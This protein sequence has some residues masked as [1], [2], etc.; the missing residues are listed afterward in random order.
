[1]ERCAEILGQCGPVA[2][3]ADKEGDEYPNSFATLA[4]A[5]RLALSDSEKAEA[6]TNSLEAQ[7]QPVNDTSSPVVTEGVNEAMRE[8]EYAPAIEPKLTSP[9]EV[10]EAIKGLKFGKAP[11]TNG[12]P[13][14]TFRNLPKRAITFLT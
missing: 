13:G 4:C 5:G 11:S 14:R 9:S 7:F 3:E 12:V 1:M 2:V 8:Y 6:L 10:L